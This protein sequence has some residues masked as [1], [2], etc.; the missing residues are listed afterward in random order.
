M[1]KNR[2]AITDKVKLQLWVKSGGRCQFKGCNDYVLRDEL[3]YAN[4]N[5]AHIAH[6]IDVNPKTHRFSDKYTEEQKN[7]L[8]NLMILCQKHHRLIDNEEEENCSIIKLSEFKKKHEDRIF[9]LTS[10]KD[11]VKTNVI[12]YF[13]KIG[14]FHPNAS[15][16]DVRKILSN[17]GLYPSTEPIEIGSKNGVIEDNEELYW[18]MEERNLIVDFEKKVITHFENN[19][20]KHFSVFAL[21]PQPL[22]IKLGTLIPDLYTVDV[23]QKHREPDTWE[24]QESSKIKKFIIHSPNKVKIGV[25]VLNIS[26]SASIDNDRI[27][28]IIGN[29]CSIWTL[30][31]DTPNNTFLTNSKTLEEFRKTLRLLFDEIKQVHGHDAIL[32][33]FPSM[34]NSSSIEFGRVWMSKADLSMDIYDERNGFKKALTIKRN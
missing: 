32:K 5:N 34:P 30:T 4:M 22:L 9:N 19:S 7:E 13:S 16:D 25:P 33:V 8:W 24:W 31:I 26:L 28:K 3:T 21:A 27:K 20:I 1:G 18:K 12:F 14:K 17:K 10:I 15:F 11:N 23:Y 6:I 2:K 29:D